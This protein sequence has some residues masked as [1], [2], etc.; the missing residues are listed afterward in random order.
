MRRRASCNASSTVTASI[1]P[2]RY[3]SSRRSTTM[4]HACWISTSSPKLA[5]NFVNGEVPA[6]REVQ[7]ARH[8]DPI[9]C[10]VKQWHLLG[11]NPCLACPAGPTQA[12]PTLSHCPSQVH[13]S[14]PTSQRASGRGC[15]AWQGCTLSETSPPSTSAH[16]SIEK[17]QHQKKQSP[18]PPTSP[19]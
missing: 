5:I 19:H 6:L 9:N 1:S 10:L 12:H 3:A 7:T 2:F 18:S 17:A 11:H 13:R 8:G 15:I 4:I 14:D 16:P